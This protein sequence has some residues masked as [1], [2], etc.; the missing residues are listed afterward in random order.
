MD[1]T[2][3]IVNL[4]VL[5]LLIAAVWLTKVFWWIFVIALLVMN[6]DALDIALGNSPGLSFAVCAAVV[7]VFAMASLVDRVL[8]IVLAI[9]SA[10]LLLYA[11]IVFVSTDAKLSAEVEDVTGIAPAQVLDTIGTTIDTHAPAKAD[12]YKKG[13]NA[14]ESISP[15]T[16]SNL[17]LE[18]FY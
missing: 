12:V 9:L 15:Q 4:L 13:K 11:S 2:K 5:A 6:F 14:W 1:V 7:G 17:G 16:A 8:V 3:H 18:L 10:L